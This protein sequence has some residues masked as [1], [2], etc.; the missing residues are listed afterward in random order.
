MR[1]TYLTLFSA[2]LA[3]GGNIASADEATEE[4]AIRYVVNEYIVGWREGDIERLS[5]VMELDNG[6]IIYRSGDGADD[7]ILS[8]TWGEALKKGRQNP[9]YGEPYEI[10]DL[11]IIQDDLANA[12]VEI[13]WP[14][15]TTY[16]DNL[17]L[18]KHGDN[19]KIILK[20][21]TAKDE[22]D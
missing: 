14:G 19:W 9:G 13:Q 20:S 17:V 18:Y 7:P 22:G 12:I 4:D 3:G 1:Y 8:V 11:N 16:I 15:R 6:H 5:K 2:L 10:V 21:F